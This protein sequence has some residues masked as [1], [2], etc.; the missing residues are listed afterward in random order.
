[1]LEQAAGLEGGKVL[2]NKSDIIHIESGSSDLEASECESAQVTPTQAAK[3]AQERMILP[4]PVVKRVV[5][6]VAWVAAKTELP[7]IL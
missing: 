4:T 5:K 3:S 7:P 2:G 1:V 6:K